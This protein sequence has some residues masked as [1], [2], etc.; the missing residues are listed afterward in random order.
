MA[1]RL[2]SSSSGLVLELVQRKWN[3]VGAHPWPERKPGQQRAETGGVDCPPNADVCTL[4]RQSPDSHQHTLDHQLVAN[5]S[6]C[7]DEVDEVDT[8]SQHGPVLPERHKEF[9]A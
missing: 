9:H 4:A 2:S 7:R 3:N 5:P 1:P 6:L 8:L